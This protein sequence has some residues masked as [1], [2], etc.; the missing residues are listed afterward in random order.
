MAQATRLNLRMQKEIR[1]LLADPPPGVS[2]PSLF[3]CDSSFSP[4][5]SI[6]ARLK[7]PEGTV[8][9][10]GIFTLKIQIP[11]RYPF[12]PPNITFVTPIYHPNIDNGGRICLDILNLPP[13]G[14][15]QPSLNI[16]TIMTSIGLLLSEPNP[17]DGLMAEISKE[18]KYNRKLFDE[19]ARSWAQKY[20]HP[21]A[22][23]KD[24]SDNM[25]SNCKSTNNNLSSPVLHGQIEVSTAEML[26][27]RPA[28]EAER[29]KKLRLMGGR[30][31]LKSEGSFNKISNEI[32]ENLVPDPVPLMA[33]V[34]VENEDEELLKEKC[35]T[36][37]QSSVDLKT[38]I[39]SDSEESDDDDD[40]R[41]PSRSRLFLVQE[42]AAS[43]W[44]NP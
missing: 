24:V 32:K 37:E 19:K 36:I 31:S 34:R 20:A 33:D 42:R 41:K 21:A 3:A 23:K 38:I 43:K 26:S 18:Y 39:V 40:A 27:D 4:L 13:K 10:E 15:W 2:F 44:K 14:A 5:S 30:L 1:L 29:G 22:A 9:S 11:E 28:A 6:E 12:Q 17:D 8:Y 16:S 7:G 25:L 35:E